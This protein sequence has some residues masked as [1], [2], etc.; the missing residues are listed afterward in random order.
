[1]IIITRV[2]IFYVQSPYYYHY[3]YIIIIIIIII[4]IAI[5][6]ILYVLSLCDYHYFVWRPIPTLAGRSELRVRAGDC[7][8]V[9]FQTGKGTPINLEQ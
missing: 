8:N 2:I 1:M 6:L 7:V 4:I 5:I 9:K 3:Y